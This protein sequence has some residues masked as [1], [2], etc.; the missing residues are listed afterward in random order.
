MVPDKVQKAEKF[1]FTYCDYIGHRTRSY[2]KTRPCQISA[3]YNPR[4][5]E[6]PMDWVFYKTEMKIWAVW[7]VR[8]V[9]KKKWI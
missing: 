7:A 9:R 4:P 1:H 2:V 6:R 8:A 5:I 3:E